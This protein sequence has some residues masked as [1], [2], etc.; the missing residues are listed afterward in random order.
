MF[1][2]TK[3]LAIATGFLALAI[4][5]GGCRSGPPATADAASAHVERGPFLVTVTSLPPPLAAPAGGGQGG[6][7]MLATTMKA[8]SGTRSRF[9]GRRVPAPV[10]ESIVK[11]PF[12]RGS[13][14][15]K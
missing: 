12:V 9:Q 2:A 8:P 5:G 11:I 14:A 7:A 10:A 4:L 6:S 3:I 13:S 1:D 15:T